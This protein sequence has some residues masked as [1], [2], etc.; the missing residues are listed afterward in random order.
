M[1]AKTGRTLKKFLGFY[2]DNAAASLV[3]IPLNQCGDVG[4]DNDE[5]ELTNWS[6]AVHGI[7]HDVPNFEITIGGV[8]DT[9][10]STGSVVVMSALSGLNV[11]LA[12]D[13]RFGCQQ[14]WESGEYCF[15]VTGTAANGCLVNNFKWN[16]ETGNWSARLRMFAGSA[17]PAWSTTAHT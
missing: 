14:A 6:D 8:A 10:A 12:F 4:L 13:F 7:L 16:P 3:N 5:V 17:A 2:I 11:P 15:G 1:T 9:T